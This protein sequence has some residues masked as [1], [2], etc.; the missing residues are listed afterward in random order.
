MFSWATLI[1]SSTN[2]FSQVTFHKS[3]SDFLNKL[4]AVDSIKPKRISKIYKSNIVDNRNTLFNMG[5]FRLIGYIP[6]TLLW[7]VKCRYFKKV[8]QNS[9]IAPTSDWTNKHKIR[10]DKGV[11]RRRDRHN[12]DA[13]VVTGCALVF[14]EWRQRL[15]YS[16]INNY[17]G[18]FMSLTL[19]YY[20]EIK[21]TCIW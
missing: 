20:R 13:M 16:Y 1:V 21:P 6:T 11:F 2:H 15:N 4:F 7:L 14:I 19:L 18:V 3:L 17:F 10:Q 8:V 12:V 5:R 9:R